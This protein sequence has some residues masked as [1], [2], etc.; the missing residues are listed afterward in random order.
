MNNYKY[1][2]GESV[3]P[4]D[5]ESSEAI[6][7]TDEMIYDKNPSNDHNSDESLENWVCAFVSKW[8]PYEFEDIL[9]LYLKKKKQY[10]CK[11]KF[12]CNGNEHRKI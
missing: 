4:Y 12:I 6:L 9:E 7:W 10:F 11:I 3:N 1:Y 2:H 5:C 8:N